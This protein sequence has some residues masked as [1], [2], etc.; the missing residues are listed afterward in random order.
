MLEDVQRGLLAHEPEQ[1]TILG[2]APEDAGPNADARLGRYGPA[3]RAERTARLRQVVEAMSPFRMTQLSSDRA[4]TRDVVLERAAGW[5]DLET[6]CGQGHLSPWGVI[7]GF[8]LYPVSQISGLH[9]GAPSLLL[10]HQ[11]VSNGAEADAYLSRLAAL[12]PALDD[13]ISE[14]VADAAV[15]P[16]PRRIVDGAIEVIDGFLA[17]PPASHPLAAAFRLNLNA[18]GLDANGVRAAM[19][20]RLLERD[21]GPAYRRLKAALV[22]IRPQSGEALGLATRPDGRDL[23]SRFLWMQADTRLS[24]AEIHARGRAE[25]ARLKSLMEGALAAQGLSRGGIQAR[26]KALS[27]QPGQLYADSDVGRAALLADLADMVAAAE[28]RMP[29]VFDRA[30]TRPPEIRR[31]LPFLEPY[32]S[33]GGGQPPSLDGRRSGVYVINLKEM[34]D[35][36]RWSLP[37]VTYH[38]ATPGHIYEGEIAM[39]A[40]H[41]AL[42]LFLARSN[43]FA[44]GWAMYAEKLAQELGLYDAYPG[45]EIGRLQSELFR[46]ARLVVDTGLHDLG[47]SFEQ[48]IAY[49]VSTG[50]ASVATARREAVRYAAWPGQAVGYKLGMMEIEAARRRA[51]AR[52]GFDLR[53]FHR[54]LLATGGL[55]VHRLTSH[56]DA[57]EV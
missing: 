17:T 16:P 14:V 22:T 6:A 13:V 42:R 57:D 27:Q 38:E 2:F 44:E 15:R 36:A 19:A 47:W 30:S 24:A 26:L 53:R 34:A 12:G 23:Y 31:I 46:A 56:L 54:R 5:L 18:A 52:P 37:S 11:P 51:E 49:M 7:W 9:I 41:P 1:A 20:E 35:V 8:E 43:G 21:V 40:G 45:S 28:A 39:S 25:V 55:P 4:L 48:A 29:R 32:A 3:G 33:G 10:N 50:A